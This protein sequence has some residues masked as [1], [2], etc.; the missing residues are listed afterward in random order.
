MKKILRT[1]K[2][3]VNAPQTPSTLLNGLKKRMIATPYEAAIIN[4]HYERKK[5]VKTW[6]VAVTTCEPPD[7]FPTHG[8][9][10]LN[11]I[12]QRALVAS[13]IGEIERV[14]RLHGA[15]SYQTGVKGFRRVTINH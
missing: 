10:M 12:L 8:A 11:I 3:L 1:I 15:R 9:W 13:I 6:T 4:G 2:A 7:T 5:G 14:E